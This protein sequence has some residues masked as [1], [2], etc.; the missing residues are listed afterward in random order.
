MGDVNRAPFVLVTTTFTMPATVAGVVNKNIAVADLTAAQRDR[1]PPRLRSLLRGTIEFMAITHKTTTG[2]G[3]PVDVSFFGTDQY[4]TSANVTQVDFLGMQRFVA[5]D[6]DLSS[7]TY[8]V[9]DAE[10]IGI[11]YRDK[12]NTGEFHVRIEIAATGAAAV[13][14]NGLLLFAWRPEISV[15]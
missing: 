12:D 8:N 3:R 11:H 1:V 9:V 6:W 10:N 2:A 5:A 15:P 14:T 13:A 7:G 4:L